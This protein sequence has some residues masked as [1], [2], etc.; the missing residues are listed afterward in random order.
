[1]DKSSYR[2]YIYRHVTAKNPHVFYIGLGSRTT[3]DLKFSTYTRAYRKDR[4]TQWKRVVKKYGYEVEILVETNDRDFCVAKEIEFIKLYGRKDK[5]EGTLINHTDGGEFGALGRMYKPSKE[6]IEKMR[7]SMIGKKMPEEFGKNVSKRMKGNHYRAGFRHSIK[8]Q[9]KISKTRQKPI[10]VYSLS[11]QFVQKFE[12]VKQTANKFKVHETTIISCAKGKQKQTKGYQFRYYFSDNIGKPVYKINMN[13]KILH[14]DLT[15][16]IETV[17]N[18][19]IE[20]SKL[21][22]I[23][24]RKIIR[25]A[26]GESK[27]T[28]INNKFKWLK[29][30]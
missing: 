25:N 4:T 6:S 26:G 16:G 24:H 29:N 22:S 19:A 18:N 1:M 11:G 17:Y 14:I 10:Y 12:S 15:T 5:R 8:T 2:Y 30:E 23:S 3:Q 7:K 28:E 27:T 21:L 9:A 20:C 13:S